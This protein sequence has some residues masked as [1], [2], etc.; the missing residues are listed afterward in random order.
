MALLIEKEDTRAASKFAPQELLQYEL[1]MS[2]YVPS[3][4]ETVDNVTN[5]GTTLFVNLFF[6]FKKKNEF[7]KARNKCVKKK[8]DT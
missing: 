5:S 7:A 6:L 3:K 2:T 4:A 8:Y 1:T